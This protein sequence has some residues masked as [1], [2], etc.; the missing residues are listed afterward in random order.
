MTKQNAKLIFILSFVLI[1]YACASDSYTYYGLNVSRIEKPE[2]EK[3]LLLHKDPKKDLD[4]TEC[5]P[6]KK[7]V[8][9]CI[10]VFSSEYFKMKRD[11][12]E[13]KIRLEACEKGN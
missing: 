4:L 6:T 7:N 11:F 13:M 9:P 10:V 5:L 3:G 12:E 1:L 2:L 8:S